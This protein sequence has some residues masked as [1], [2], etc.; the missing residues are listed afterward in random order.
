[1]TSICNTYFVYE[2]GFW[3]HP[4][5]QEEYE[6]FMPDASY[7]EFVKAQWDLREGYPKARL[8]PSRTSRPGTTL[9]LSEVL[10]IAASVAFRRWNPSPHRYERPVSPS[11]SVPVLSSDARG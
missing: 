7:E 9:A 8:L 1:L 5:S 11:S 6:L 10:G 3:R 4:F 2:D